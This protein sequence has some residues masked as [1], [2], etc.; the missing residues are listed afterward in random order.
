MSDSEFM[1]VFEDGTKMKTSSETSLILY[2]I[3]VGNLKTQRGI[4]IV[5]Q[6][7]AFQSMVTYT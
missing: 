2:I 6:N 3:V 7:M 5:G 1:H 4:T